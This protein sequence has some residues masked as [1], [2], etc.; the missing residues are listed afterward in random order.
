VHAQL[1]WVDPKQ[2]VFLWADC[3]SEAAWPIKR[4]ALSL[5]QKESLAS[6]HEPRSLVRAAARL[7]TSQITRAR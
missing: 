7:V 4:R 2:E 3:R 1:I 5:L 6:G